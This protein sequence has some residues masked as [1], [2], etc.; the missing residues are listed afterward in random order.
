M[1]CATHRRTSNQP[2]LHTA[3]IDTNVKAQLDQSLHLL[4]RPRKAMHQSPLGQLVQPSLQMPLKVLAG[5]PRVQEQRELHINR[6]LQLRLE[7]LELL[8]LGRQ[9][10]AIIV[11]PELAKRNRMARLLRLGG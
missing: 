6:N 10:K 1:S 4:H 11:E 2:T 7:I 3:S 5:R 8:L 9:K